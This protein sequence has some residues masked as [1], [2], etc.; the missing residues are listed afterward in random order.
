MSEKM[1]PIY[2][3]IQD[4]SVLA[5]AGLRPCGLEEVLC[6]AIVDPSN[7]EDAEDE[8]GVTRM[9]HSLCDFLE[10]LGAKGVD[11]A[12]EVTSQWTMNRDQPWQAIRQIVAWDRMLGVWCVCQAARE[13][14]KFIPENEDR[15]RVAIESAELWVTG[16]ATMSQLRKASED[17]S[18]SSVTFPAASASAYAADAA[19]YAADAAVA[20]NV[21]DAV[22]SASSALQSVCYALVPNPPRRIFNRGISAIVYGRKSDPDSRPSDEEEAAVKSAL[23]CISKAIANACMTFPR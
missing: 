3:A 13:T 21:I 9:P 7:A 18:R 4:R 15:P 22:N 17:A 8:L 19:S 16:K 5:Y 6:A 1:H 20:T 10:R 23:L 11:V 14:L 12:L 2:T